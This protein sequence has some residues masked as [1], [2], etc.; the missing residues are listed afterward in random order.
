M[1][2]DSFSRLNICGMSSQEV[3]KFIRELNIHRPKIEVTPSQ[4]L[5]GLY[6]VV[7]RDASEQGVVRVINQ[8]VLTTSPRL[9]FTIS[10]ILIGQKISHTADRYDADI[11][12]MVDPA[13]Q[14]QPLQKAGFVYP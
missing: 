13:Y 1:T 10:G 12:D 2:N 7:D 3:S 8:D 4:D 5:K 11:L 6:S 14:P 9:A